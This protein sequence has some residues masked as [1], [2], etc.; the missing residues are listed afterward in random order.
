M[1]M[2][3]NF[4]E[5]HSFQTDPQAESLKPNILE[6]VEHWQHSWIFWISGHSFPLCFSWFL[7]FDSNFWSI[8]AIFSEF[9]PFLYNGSFV[10][11]SEFWLSWFSTDSK[12][13]YR[14][15]IWIVRIVRSLAYRTFQLSAVPL[16]GSEARVA[17]FRRL[18]RL[19]GPSAR[20]VGRGHGGRPSPPPP[21]PPPFPSP[22]GRNLLRLCY[23]YNISP[24]L[25]ET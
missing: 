16:E 18:V 22:R 17:T 19:E 3:R 9:W 12:N 8:L 2:S 25:Q 1:K 5:Y 14:T 6:D 10:A 13:S 21:T 11:F 15:L 20:L 7:G 4:A 24:Y 23:R